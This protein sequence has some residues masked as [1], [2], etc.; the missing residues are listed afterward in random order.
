MAAPQITHAPID[1][2]TLWKV[3]A[4]GEDLG[5]RFELTPGGITWETMPGLRHQELALQVYGSVRPRQIASGCGCYPG[6]DVYVW[7][8][9][10]T[11]K[12]PDISIFC[13][14]PEEEEGFIHMVP[15]AVI[16][17]TSPDSEAKDLVA[18][19]PLYLENGVKDVVVHQRSQNKVHH[20]TS[21]GCRIQ[22]SGQSITLACGCELQI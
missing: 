11:V 4:Q 18:G 2:Q 17:I 20:F 13:R 15:E 12:R 8:P 9:N 22:N 1:E 5:L 19:P 21:E 7:L 14:R 10:G 3:F 16:E 6:F